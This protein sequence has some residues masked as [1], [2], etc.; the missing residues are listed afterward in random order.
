M[1]AVEKRQGQN[2]VVLMHA[3][4]EMTP[5]VPDLTAGPNYTAVGTGGVM[6]TILTGGFGT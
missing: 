4:T 1:A 5:N 3:A 6:V 2:K